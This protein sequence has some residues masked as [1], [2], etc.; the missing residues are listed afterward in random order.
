MLE[1]LYFILNIWNFI[2]VLTKKEKKYIPYYSVFCRW[3]EN[4]KEEK[5]VVVFCALILNL[6]CPFLFLQ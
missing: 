3:R 1:E 5:A 6:S 4:R 2:L